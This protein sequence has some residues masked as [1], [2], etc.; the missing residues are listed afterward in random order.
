MPEVKNT[1]VVRPSSATIGNV[2]AGVN[3]PIYKIKSS[4][5]TKL[6]KEDT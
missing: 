3:P 5:G 4:P 1:R 2:S 6:P